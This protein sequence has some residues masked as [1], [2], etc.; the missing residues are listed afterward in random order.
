MT[1]KS[2]QTDKKGDYNLESKIF[3]ITNIFKRYKITDLT[4]PNELGTT[5]NKVATKST[6]RTRLWKRLRAPSCYSAEHTLLDYTIF[7]KG[8]AQCIQDWCQR[9]NMTTWTRWGSQAS[10]YLS[11][12]WS[13]ISCWSAPDSHKTEWNDQPGT[14]EWGNASHIT[15]L[16]PPARMDYP[17]QCRREISLSIISI[18]GL[19][20]PTARYTR[21]TTHVRGLL[22]FT[23]YHIHDY[24]TSRSTP[25]P[26]WFAA[27]R[28][29]YL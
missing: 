22:Y 16:L 8:G 19:L 29:G 5:T 13:W 11:P 6:E 7:F 3:S 9:H 20:S 18:T 21:L 17:A 24:K 25:R 15:R 1:L 26:Y 27:A 14:A 4:R 12:M 23:N 28:Q 2:T 10:V